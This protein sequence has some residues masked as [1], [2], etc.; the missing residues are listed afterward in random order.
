MESQN[1]LDAYYDE[2]LEVEKLRLKENDE[3]LTIV[4]S[5]V[6]N[7]TYKDILYII[8]ESDWTFN[9]VIKNKPKGKYQKEDLDHLIGIW[10]NQTTDGGYSG[11]E[12]AGTISIEIGED[13]Y[14]Q[15]SYSM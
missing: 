10:V 3:I 7:E 4:K 13:E 14:F 15:F 2:M 9:Y 5:K 12:F 8:T 11:D 6:T 1:E